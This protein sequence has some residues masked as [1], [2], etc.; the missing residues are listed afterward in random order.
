MYADEE[1]G[2]HDVGLVLLSGGEYCEIT[3]NPLYLISFDKQKEY[4]FYRDDVPVHYEYRA[5]HVP[6]YQPGDYPEIDDAIQADTEEHYDKDQILPFHLIA[7]ASQGRRAIAYLKAD[8]DNLGLLLRKGLDWHTSGW[9]LSK[10]ATFSRSLEFFFSGRIN[11]ILRCSYPMIYTVFSGGD[12]LLLVGP[13]NHLHDFARQLRQE[14]KAY[15]FG[16]P[17]LTLSVGVSLTRPMTR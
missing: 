3:G 7:L 15:T 12:D 6:T 14:W 2:D 9:T 17:Q 16:N 4:S 1:S 8:L 5:M 11:N 10:M 13:W